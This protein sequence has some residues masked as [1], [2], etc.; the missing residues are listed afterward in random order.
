MRRNIFHH[1]RGGVAARPGNFRAPA[2]H[3]SID[4]P[5]P[6]VKLSTSELPGAAGA[7]VVDVQQSVAIVLVY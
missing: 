6:E 4:G 2:G 1:Q 5:A 7:L 3:D